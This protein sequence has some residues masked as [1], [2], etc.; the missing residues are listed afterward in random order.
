MRSGEG[1]L[2]SVSTAQVV[3]FAWDVR[4]QPSLP[5]LP[6]FFKPPQHCVLGY[7]QPSS[8]GGLGYALES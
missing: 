7:F 4:F 2:N 6:R 3:S 1:R 8:F 5:G